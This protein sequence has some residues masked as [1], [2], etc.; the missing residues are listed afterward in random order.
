MSASASIPSPAAE[1]L[2][3][4]PLR[5]RVAVIVPNYNGRHHLATCLESLAAQRAEAE[6]ALCVA[7]NGSSDGSSAFLEQRFPAVRLV[8]LPTNQGFA[9]AC[10]AAAREMDVEVLAFLNNDMRVEPDWLEHLLVPL[11]AGAAE[12]S[13]SRIVDWEGRTIDFAGGGMN[14]HG[15]GIARGHGELDGPQHRVAG[16]SL[17]ACGGS[18]AIRRDVFLAAGGFDE[19]FFAY[20]EDVDLGWRLW[21]LGYRVR[22][23]PASLTYHHLSATS[24]TFGYERVRLLQVRNPLFAIAKN[25]GERA[26]QRI[27]PAAL[28]LTA[29]RT[30]YMARLPVEAFRIELAE[31]GGSGRFRELLRKAREGLE[32]RLAISKVALADL[33]ALHDFGL[34]LPRLLRERAA[35]QARR[36]REDRE[37]FR[38]FHDPFWAVEPPPEYQELQRLLCDELGIRE[39]FEDS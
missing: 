21:V 7:D 30:F 15:I 23:E 39:L 22:Y 9:A 17:F 12:A 19:E 16:P 26:F 36:R 27:L 34:H 35:I 10:N 37:I 14:F 33:V 29:Q 32:D 8:R 6:I 11:R 4:L 13:T 3:R 1:E 38:L 2:P 28:L 31:G 5:P 20:Y 25:Y 18:M 24:R